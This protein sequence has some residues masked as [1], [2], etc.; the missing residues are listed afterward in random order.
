MKRTTQPKKLN[1]NKKVILLLNEQ[2]KRRMLAGTSALTMDAEC[3]TT[4][5]R[6]TVPRSCPSANA[7]TTA[8]TDTCTK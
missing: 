8:P 1:L 4:G 5:P 6:T 7:C 2:Q 3:D